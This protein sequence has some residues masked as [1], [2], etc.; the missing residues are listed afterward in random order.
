MQNYSNR[1]PTLSRE[2]DETA[3]FEKCVNMLGEYKKDAL[4][5]HGYFKNKSEKF[6]K[7]QYSLYIIAHNKKDETHILL[8]VPS[9]YGA[10]LEED[11]L[12]SGQTA[13]EFFEGNSIKEIV[14]FETKFGTDSY[15][16]VI[17]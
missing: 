17:Y 13:E 2:I 12:A 8:N 5:I 14:E 16:I 1:K 6:N 7:Y 3:S 10:K 9:W 4:T 15:N 11:F